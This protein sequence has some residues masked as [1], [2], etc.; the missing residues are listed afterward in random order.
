MFGGHTYYNA[1]KERRMP[2]QPA[3]TGE[4]PAW[5]DTALDWL[6]SQGV[7][8]VLLVV[9]LFFLGYVI[10]VLGPQHLTTIQEG[11]KDQQNDFK[12][13]LREQRTDFTG[14]LKEQ[15]AEFLEAVKEKEAVTTRLEK[16]LEKAT[17]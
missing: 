1:L 2:E 13:V 14:S 4:R 9:I 10:I 6:L 3:R 17:N 12:E 8:T 11:F 7:S 5:K 15:R 16:A